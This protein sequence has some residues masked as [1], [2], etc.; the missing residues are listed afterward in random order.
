MRNDLRAEMDRA[1]SLQDN[2]YDVI[3]NETKVEL[4][5]VLSRNRSMKWVDIFDSLTDLHT[6]ESRTRRPNSQSMPLLP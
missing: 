5:Q 4:W 2:P 6:R 1:D 3:N